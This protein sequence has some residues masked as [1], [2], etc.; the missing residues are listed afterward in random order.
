M[1]TTVHNQIR[2]DVE[3]RKRLKMALNMLHFG[4]LVAFNGFLKESAVILN[5]FWRNL[6]T[7]I[8][9]KKKNIRLLEI[10]LN[11]RSNACGQ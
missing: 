8:H 6:K 5:V 11:G 10:K 7:L 4:E 3:D 2:I 1:L 9:S